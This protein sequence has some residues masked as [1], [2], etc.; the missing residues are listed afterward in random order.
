ML[1]NERANFGSKIGIILAS[2]GS[3]V[4][5][6]NIWRFPCEVGSNGGA[7]FIL[8]YLLCIALLGIPVMV[9]EFLIGRHSRANTASAYKILAPGTQWKWLGFMGVIAAFLILS[10]YA[11]VAGWTLE[12]TVA[13]ATDQFS[14]GG[15]FTAFFNTFVSNPWKPALYMAIFLLLTH[16]VIIRGV[17]EGIEKFSKVM[18]PMLLLIICVL[19]ICSFS[20]PG[21]VEGLT[22]LLKP[23]FSKVTTKVVLSAMGQAFF[24]LSLGMGCLCTYASY[25]SNE[26]NLMKTAASVATID[27]IVAVMAG[28]IIFPAV[29]SVQGLS[30]DA[31]PGLVFVTLPNVFQIA[32]G[33]VP[34]LGYI[35]SLMFYVLLVLAALTSTISLH[36]V[37]TAYI[38][39]SYH[40]SRSKAAYIVTG[41]CIFL[42]V[43]CSLSFGV[44]SDATWMGMTIFDLFDFVTAK[45]IMPLGGMFISIFT[46][47]YLDRKLVRD[48]VTN[49][50]RLRLPFFGLYIFILKYVAPLAIGAIFLNELMK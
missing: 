11:V 12:Y 46:G 17:K 8:I 32:F 19:V 13:A 7:A 50:G 31:G 2:A 23:D 3:A 27:T 45:F 40:I 21:S 47:W 22:F 25:F 6:G 18:M 4:G 48:E 33:N 36:E 35:F 26:A 39:E 14:R 37:S 15:D 28:F 16:I 44:L 29:Y 43:F 41:G 10:Y 42:G 34:W 24:S 38:H 5:L 1:S 20:M 49:K 30:P 9:S